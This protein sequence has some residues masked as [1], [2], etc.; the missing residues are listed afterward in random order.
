MIIIAAK[1][2]NCILICTPDSI[3]KNVCDELFI[4]KNLKATGKQ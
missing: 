1:L 3:I 2:A 4:D